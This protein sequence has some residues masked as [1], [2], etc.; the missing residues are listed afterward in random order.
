MTSGKVADLI[1]LEK[2]PLENIE[3]IGGINA[4]MKAGKL[5][6]LEDSNRMLQEIRQDV[7]LF[8]Q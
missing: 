4:V 5:Y 2:N 8:Q 7:N 6:D 1:L 3:N